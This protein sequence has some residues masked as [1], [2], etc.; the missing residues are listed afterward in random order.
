MLQ[1]IYRQD[2][3]PGANREAAAEMGVTQEMTMEPDKFCNLHS[4]GE[5]GKKTIEEVVHHLERKQEDLH[6]IS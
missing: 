1:S 5:R 2:K 6:H 4:A 3:S